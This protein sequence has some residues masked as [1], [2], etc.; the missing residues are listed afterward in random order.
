MAPILLETL[1]MRYEISIQH[2]IDPYMSLSET[3][4]APAH[5]R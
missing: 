1:L 5:G 3:C 2:G 4:E